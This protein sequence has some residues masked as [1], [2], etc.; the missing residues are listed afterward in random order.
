MMPSRT[1]R[2]LGFN[3]FIL[4]WFALL[5]CLALHSSLPCLPCQAPCLPWLGILPV[6]LSMLHILASWILALQALLILWIEFFWDAL[7]INSL[8]CL[9]SLAYIAALGFSLLGLAW[10][11]WMAG[12]GWAGLAWI[13]L[14]DQCF[15]GA[16]TDHRFR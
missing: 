4:D 9:A 10:M 5:Y 15:G 14:I 6:L 12:P 16:A 13:I 11:A 1:A 3:V 8:G 7:F 2:R